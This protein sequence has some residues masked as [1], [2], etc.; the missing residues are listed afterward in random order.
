M[1]EVFDRNQDGVRDVTVFCS[2]ALAQMLCTLSIDLVESEVQCC[3]CLWKMMDEVFDRKQNG[4]CDATV[5][6]C[7]ALARCSTP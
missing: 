5:F 3:E 7:S 6:C 4:V 1:H 2:S